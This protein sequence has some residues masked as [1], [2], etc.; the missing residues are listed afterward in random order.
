MFAAIRERAAH[1]HQFVAGYAAI[2]R[3]PTPRPDRVEWAE[4]IADLARQQAFSL[5]GSLPTQPGWFDRLQL[6][7]A[8]INVL[9]NAHESGGDPA[10]VSLLVQQSAHEARIEIFDRG[11]GMTDL[12]LAQ[13]LLPF[14]STKRDGTGLGLAMC[15]EI[16][17]AHGGSLRLSNREDGRLCGTLVLPGYHP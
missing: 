13:A 9:K 3:L 4:L 6:E 5:S 10:Q 14:Y 8:L 12:V 1:L 16:T 2:A 7:Q 15:R 17:E 11:P